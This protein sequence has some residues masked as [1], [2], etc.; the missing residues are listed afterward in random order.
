MEIELVVKGSKRGF[1][2]L[3]ISILIKERYPE[4]QTIPNCYGVCNSPEQ[5]IKKF[6]K[7]LEDDSITEVYC[8]HI[9]KIKS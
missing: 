4:I 7:I 5:F 8:H 9:Y 1:S 6:E 2:F 3:V